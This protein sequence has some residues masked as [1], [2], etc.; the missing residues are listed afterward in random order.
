MQIHTY[1]QKTKSEYKNTL[2]SRIRQTHKRYIYIYYKR[3]LHFPHERFQPNIYFAK[4]YTYCISLSLS[5]IQ[6]SGATPCN[7]SGPCIV[8]GE[9]MTDW[10]EKKNVYIYIYVFHGHVQH[11][12]KICSNSNMMVKL[13]CASHAPKVSTHTCVNWC[14][15][16]IASRQLMLPKF[17]GLISSCFAYSRETAPW[18]VASF[19]DTICNLQ[20][21]VPGQMVQYGTLVA[22]PHLQ[23]TLQALKWLWTY[24]HINLD[25]SLEIHYRYNRNIYIIWIYKYIFTN[26]SIYIHIY[27]YS[28]LNLYI[29]VYI[30][31]HFQAVVT[32]RSSSTG[33]TLAAL[34]FSSCFAAFLSR[35]FFAQ[36]CSR[37]ARMALRSAWSGVLFVF[38]PQ[39]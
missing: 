20:I 30:Y 13:V 3:F 33:Y 27:I 19:C 15:G 34:T 26:V 9:Q 10:A 11:E 24:L 1:S 22:S 17:C 16:I 5:S 39:Q 2:K 28:L 31:I 36:C 38:P 12:R 4:K 6:I 32:A 18:S 37:T 8:L 29:Y 35:G 21:N 7:R 25:I 23:F 14:L